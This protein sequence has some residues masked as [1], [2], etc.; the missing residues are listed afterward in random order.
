MGF[1]PF[2][3]CVCHCL[4]SFKQKESCKEIRHPKKRKGTFTTQ[5]FRSHRVLT[6]HPGIFGNYNRKVV[7]SRKQLKRQLL[8]TPTDRRNLFSNQ[9]QKFVLTELHQTQS[10]TIK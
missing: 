2:N 5:Y 7:F 6:F 9:K 10:L 1:N 8:F 4:E 3:L